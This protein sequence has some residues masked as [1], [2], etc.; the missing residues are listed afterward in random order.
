MFKCEDCNVNLHLTVEDGTYTTY[1][2]KDDG[3]LEYI[4]SDGF[5]QEIKLHCDECQQEYKF[6]NNLMTVIEIPKL[7]WF[8][9]RP[10]PVRNS[11]WRFLTSRSGKTVNP[12]ARIGGR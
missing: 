2:F 12:C 8:G 7:D 5:G 4:D 11:V 9:R 3:S 6:D 10:A 1:Q